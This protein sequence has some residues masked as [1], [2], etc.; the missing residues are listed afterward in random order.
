MDRSDRLRSLSVVKHMISAM[1]ML[2]NVHE[3]DI[4]NW[5]L[6]VSCTSQQRSFVLSARHASNQEDEPEWMT[7]VSRPRVPC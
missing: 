7:W 1:L 2:R 3:F 4:K 6:G 5:C